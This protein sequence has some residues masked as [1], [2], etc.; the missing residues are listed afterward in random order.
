MPNKEI[1]YKQVPE[2][3]IPL[4]LLL[5]ADPSEKC[6]Q[7]YLAN[8]YCFAA[9]HANTII[10]AI[11]ANDVAEDLIEIFNVAVR[12][13]FQQKGIG[14][15]L[16]KFSIQ[17]FKSMGTKRVEIGTGSFGYQLQYYHR[18]GFRVESVLKNHFVQCY[19]QPIYENG[20]QHKD[21]LRLYIEL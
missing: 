12:P 3:T 2:G 19:S 20:I 21:M 11:V 14:G 5:L 6:V 15:E 13:D 1:T 9:L 18:A 8:S 10:G 16:L 4:D 7:K 17:H